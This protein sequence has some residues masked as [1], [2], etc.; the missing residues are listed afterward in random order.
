MIEFV[1]Q[2]SDKNHRGP[3]LFSIKR[4]ERR[5]SSR[6]W[7]TR[8]TWESTKRTESKMVPS[9]S[10]QNGCRRET[11][12]IQ[13]EQAWGIDW[14]VTGRY[15]W[16]CVHQIVRLEARI[17][18]RYKWHPVAPVEWSVVPGTR[19]YVSEKKGRRED[20]GLQVE[21]TAANERVGSLAKIRFRFRSG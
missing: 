15:F 5:L 19:G 7:A 11:D 20:L 3:C 17:A 21:S 1:V 9:D 14:V 2:K 6:K 4:K 13:D 8:C 18:T 10:V 12:W 16:C